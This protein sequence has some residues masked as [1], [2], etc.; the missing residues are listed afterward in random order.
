MNGKNLPL[1]FGI[2]A[3][4]VALSITSLMM[5]GLRLGIDLKG[6]A[7]IVYRILPGEEGQEAD[8]GLARRMIDVLK[9]R[10][11]PGGLGNLEWRP[12]GK[13]R[14][15]IRMPAPRADSQAK[16]DAYIKAL[17]ALDAKNIT[18]S[19]INR[20]ASV[21]AGPERQKALAALVDPT[22]Y[23]NLI[24]EKQTALDQAK[25]DKEKASAQ[26]ALDLAK[27]QLKFAT[28][29][30]K[31]LAALVKAQDTV[32]ETT[33]NAQAEAGAEWRQRESEFKIAYDLRKVGMENV[34]SRYVAARGL[35]D[36]KQ[37]RLRMEEFDKALARLHESFPMRSADIDACQDAHKEWL[38]V[39]QHLEDP[40]DLKRLVSRAGQL[41]FRIAPGAPRSRAEALP[42]SDNDYQAY[43]K[44]LRA[45]G[46]DAAWLVNKSK[47]W[48][49]ANGTASDYMSMVTGTF[50]GQLYVLLETEPHNTLLQKRGQ[51][52][53]SLKRSS[54]TSD[55]MGR[56]AV[57][58][59]FDERGARRFSDLT[60]AHTG[61]FMAVLL[62]DMVY[63]CPRINERISNTGII[64]GSF[65][66]QEVRELVQI[67]EA[68][69][70]PA[71]LDPNPVSES[72]FGPAIGEV[73]REMGYR[74]AFAGIIAVA[75]FMLVYYVKAGF[76]ADV[77]LLLN[78]VLVV[79]VMSMFDVVL[80]LPG[81]AGVILTVGIAVDANVL[82]FERLREEQERGQSVGVAIKN[83]YERALSAI[84]DANITTLVTC[85]IL[86]WVS[87]EEVKGFAITLG[88]GVA[89][90]LFTAL[91]VTRWVFQAMAKA[92]LLNKP[93]FMLHLIGVPKINWMAKRKWFWSVS[94]VI[95][96][97]GVIAFAT[98][99]KDVFG[100]EFSGGTKAVLELKD[101]ELIDGK[102]PS[103]ELIRMKLSAAADELDLIQFKGT[104]R[105]EVLED[106]KRAE[107]FLAVYDKDESGTVTLDELPPADGKTPAKALD[108]LTPYFKLLVTTVDANGDNILDADDLEGLPPLSYQ[109]TT[110]E[111]R[112][113]KV[114][115]A[116]E[117]ALR[118]SLKR[119]SACR[120]DVIK[121][122]DVRGA[123]F[124]A[125]GADGLRRINLVE[126]EEVDADLEDFNGGL[127]I[128]L[129]NLSPALPVEEITQRISDMRFQP[130]YNAQRQNTS[131]IVPLKTTADGKC[132]SF[133]LLV[134]HATDSSLSDKEWPIFAAGENELLTAALKRAESTVAVNIDPSIAGETAQSAIVAVILSWLA[135][136]GYLWLRFGSP[137]WGLAA[138][139][140]LVH[141]VVIVLG[142]VAISNTVIGRMLGC[143]G[144]KIDLPMI[145]AILTV[146]GYSVNDTIVVFD[147]IRENRGRLTAISEQTINAS[148]NQT[149]GRTLLTSSTTF[150][151]VLI[152]FVWGGQGIHAFNYALLMGI[153]FGTYSSIAIAS[154]LLLGFKE[155]I[156]AKAVVI[157]DE[158]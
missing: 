4:V 127:M 11:D 115:D 19:K 63:S 65:S 61:H 10:V 83:A 34:L 132:V 64:S 62:D 23:A 142:M 98:Q 113:A 135:I 7:E 45:H 3:I 110:T 55:D 52:D 123:S 134:Q 5:K 70:L 131:K 15:A 144:F 43:T 48:F 141:D 57:R 90:S 30:V 44:A 149:L 84:F 96:V 9:K 35:A 36:S 133:A 25:D 29:L 79:G 151:V 2:L 152:M 156:A 16:R 100:I 67:L 121:G 93:V 8:S 80:T 101:G 42:I 81:I 56:P 40:A 51:R 73:S 158:A 136:V 120:F 71:R 24:E 58:F 91:V 27:R 6:G 21:P 138:V 102:L 97:C 31:D 147:R 154:P 109:V 17:E 87:T 46:P 85:L 103:D 32:R 105:V 143:A 66:P 74:A 153:I 39:R 111:T 126:G 95:L 68:G 119:R 26:K 20:L 78:I 104:A 148:I 86:G 117:T 107:N 155:A 88:L 150:I 69:S 112:I 76:I 146:I 108:G 18:A 50:A 49:P 99:G 47:R 13:D 124:P 14:F 130:D 92:G 59:E 53:W 116:A 22:V 60:G 75:I 94:A 118:A 122:R 28:R 139:V 41:E 129:E 33:G 82:I 157:A 137:Q 140:C 38:R 37:A 106:P 128:A 1:K 89:F 77:A 72:K 114:R 145:A 12:M 54:P 125:A